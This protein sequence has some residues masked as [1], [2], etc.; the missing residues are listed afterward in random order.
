MVG[1]WSAARPAA[2]PAGSAAG[3]HSSAVVGGRAGARRPPAHAAALIGRAAPLAGRRSSGRW[4]PGNRWQRRRQGCS[5]LLPLHRRRLAADRR[6]L[7]AFS[8]PAAVTMVQRLTYR[9]RHSYATKSNKQRIVRTP[10][11]KLVYQLAKKK[12]S[13]PTCPISGQRLNGVSASCWAGRPGGWVSSRQLVPQRRRRQHQPRQDAAGWANCSGVARS[14]CRGAWSALQW[15]TA[16]GRQA[17]GRT[18]GWH[19]M[20]ASK[21]HGGAPAAAP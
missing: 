6:R 1:A 21:R 7:P 4:T 8:P 13:H 11:G 12:T 2:L 20:G 3:T 19:R 16:A 14:C 10:G 15:R 17:A 18:T 5:P 9:R